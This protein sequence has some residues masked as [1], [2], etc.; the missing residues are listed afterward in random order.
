VEAAEYD[1]MFRIETSYWWHVGK[2]RLVMNLIR[3]WVA[4]AGPLRVLDVGCGTGAHLLALS[5]F[6]PAAGC[7]VSPAAVAYARSRGLDGVT[8]QPDPA[9][10]PF[11]DSSFDLVT[12]LDV[13]EHADD[14]EQLAREIARVLEP[15]GAALVTVPAHPALWSVHDESVHHKRRYRQGELLRTLRA[16]GLHPARTTYLNGLLLPLIVPVRWLRDRWPRSHG[17]T[18]DFNLPLPRWLNALF[19]FVFTAEWWWIRR[20]P[21]PFGLTICCLARKPKADG[22]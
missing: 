11:P 4:P 9:R 19:L 6:G 12:A 22:G 7:D 10:L 8:H 15:G 18:S 13:I 3:R 17:A 14:D 16:A 21:L 5:A 1:L 20:W 2:R